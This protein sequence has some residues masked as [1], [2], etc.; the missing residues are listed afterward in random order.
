[1]AIRFSRFYKTKITH[2]AVQSDNHGGFTFSTPTILK[3][4]WEQRIDNVI[5]PDGEEFVSKANVWVASDVSVGDYLYLGESVA[6]D[7][8]TLDGAYRV[9]VFGKVPD[10]RG[11]NFERKTI[12]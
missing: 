5:S 11:T 1:M 2:W 4:R 9:Q 8:T 6:A 7:P 3:G 10:I 12:L